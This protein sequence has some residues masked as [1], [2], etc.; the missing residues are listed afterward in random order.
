[1]RQ[2]GFT[3]AEILGVIV[4]IGLLLVL[5]VPMVIDRISSSGEDV[6]D[7]ENE[8]I[9]NAAEQYIKEHP[10]EYPSG[11][12]GRYCIPIQTLIDDGKLAE[13]VV[14]VTTGED[15]SDKSVMITIYSSGNTDYEL[16][17]GDECEELSSLPLIDFIVEPSGS[18]WVKS[19]KVTIIYPTIDGDYEASH[20]ID[21]GSWVRDSSADNGGNIELTFTESGILEARLKGTQVISSK[22]SISN[23]DSEKPVVRS[24]STPSEWSNQTQTATATVYDGVSGIAGYYLS[25]SSTA[26][27]EDDSNWVSVSYDAGEVTIE[28]TNLS[29]GTY[30]LWVKDKAGNVSDTTSNSKFVI[31]NIDTVAPSCTIEVGSGDKGNN[32]WYTS[33]VRLDLSYSDDSS[34]V[35]SYGI[36][37]SKTVSYNGSK[38]V[39][40]SSDTSGTTYY[41]YV[42]DK[43]GNTSSCNI[44]VKRDATKPTITCSLTL[45]D[46]TSYVQGTWSRSAITR[47]IT[48]SDATSG[49]SQI[50]NNSSG[51]WATDSSASS[52][53][54][55]E[56]VY[57]YSFRSIDAAGNVSDTCSINAKID[58]TAP[59][60]CQTLWTGWDS[61]DPY[62]ARAYVKA[63]D[64]LSGVEEK[65]YS[66]YCYR[67]T[68]CGG[69]SEVNCNNSYSVSSRR[70]A[71][72]WRDESSSS[73]NT[74]YIGA[75]SFSPSCATYFGVN[76]W[77]KFC[78]VA[79]NCMSDYYYTEIS[80]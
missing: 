2:K 43:A 24:V 7:T 12:S 14:D 40:I 58:W 48:A 17:E 44:T 67:G 76:F 51:S 57:S 35:A 31:D 65:S 5:I 11:K 71:N 27:S 64:N 55:S 72:V 30:Y 6:S 60:I 19:R 18:S 59:Y 73:D 47:K 80:Y 50:Q 33:N 4:I 52:L 25:T 78:D 46:G 34:G 70:V 74:T 37:T 8:L 23:V 39:T 54:L 9:F 61:N 21:S 3:L 68:T 41:G 63:C 16:K 15:I 49:V 36:T 53:S 28:L 77:W 79:G 10:N 26:P 75:T 45:P 62:S 69:T 42:V 1:M 38:T 66:R 20:R 13:P 29:N 32:G 22:I 56:G